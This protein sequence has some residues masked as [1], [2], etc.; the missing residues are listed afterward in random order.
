MP[1]STLGLAEPL[2][3][4]LEAAGFQAPFPIQAQAIPPALAGRDLA[5]V[6][7]T[8]SGKTAAFAL[9]I[10]QRLTQ[11][12]PAER[13]PVR[14][15]VLVPTRE[16]AAQVGEAFVQLGRFLP[17]PPRTRVVFGGSSVNPQMMALRG[18]TDILVATPGRLLDLVTRNA[19]RLGQ[20]ETLVL[21]EADRMLDL[22]F[23]EELEKLLELLPAH[24]Q[25]LLFSATG[26]PA[27]GSLLRPMLSNPLELAG[28]TPTLPP[29]EVKQRVYLVDQAR[30]GPL[31]RHLILRGGW[32]QVL[33]FVASHRRADTVAR[34]LQNHGIGAEAMHGD[35]SQGARTGA[36]A[37]FKAGGT[38]VLVATDLASRGLDIEN[39]ACVINYELP[40]SPNDYLHRVGRTG[41]AGAAGVAISLVAPEE[42]QHM[43][44][45]EKRMGKRIP[46][47][48]AAD[49]AFE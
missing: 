44:L 46:H 43:I 1:F 29:E 3:R 25:N 21:D 38:R 27:T 20:V 19:V 33:V 18:G 30:K 14:A 48:D 28:P 10:L 31:L 17:T 4:A 11:G 32:D 37:G 42:L 12:A 23:Q 8:G 7:P 13:G 41:R 34:K 36:L 47:L 5:A 16:L 39:L 26:D 9:P 15:L 49:M 35:L 22:G 24:R 6:A 45:I 2:L 40:R